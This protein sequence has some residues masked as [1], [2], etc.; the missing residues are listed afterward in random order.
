MGG[1][2]D[3]SDRDLAGVLDG[4]WG[5]HGRL[6]AD[7]YDAAAAHVLELLEP[8]HDERAHRAEA[9]EHARV[10]VEGDGHDAWVQEVDPGAWAV[11]CWCAGLA[12]VLGLP[13]ATPGA[14]GRGEAVP[15][16]PFPPGEA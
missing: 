4:L 9:L 5:L 12:L 11:F 10:Q 1:V 14:V 15:S 6:M 3:L 16:S 7:G 13:T 8:A 2:H